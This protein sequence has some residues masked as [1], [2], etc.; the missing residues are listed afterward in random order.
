MEKAIKLYTQALS[1]VQEESPSQ[2]TALFEI[3]QQRAACYHRLGDVDAGGPGVVAHDAAQRVVDQAADPPGAQAQPREG[4]GH[5]VLAASD[6]DLEMWGE[7]DAVAAGWAEADHALAQ[8][9]QVELALLRRSDAQGHGSFPF[10]GG[11]AW[12]VQQG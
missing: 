1:M 3:L 2:S 4:V 12:M 5:V 8:A 7:L 9:D 6:V 10:S 11:P